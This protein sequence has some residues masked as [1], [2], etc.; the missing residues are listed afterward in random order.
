MMERRWQST[1]PSELYQV[2]S[3]Q[4]AAFRAEDYPS[5]YRQ[6]SMSFQEKVDIEAFADLARTE[7][8]ALLQA[9]RVEFG[10]VRFDGRHAVLSAYFVLPEGDIIP[11]VYRLVREDEGWKIET[12]RV[13]PRWPSSRRLGGFRA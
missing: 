5:A 9:S 12:V 7:Y 1:P 2:V 3:S 8:P 4:L 11:C 6:V 13:Q 10:Q